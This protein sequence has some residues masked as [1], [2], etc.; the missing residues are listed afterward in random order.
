M[1]RAL[2]TVLFLACGLAVAVTAQTPPPNHIDI[3]GRG[4]ARTRTAPDPII[5]NGKRAMIL[6]ASETTLDGR[7]V[8]VNAAENRLVIEQEKSRKHF[9]ISLNPKTKLKADRGTELAGKEKIDITDFKPGQR[10]KVI[11]TLGPTVVELRLRRQKDGAATQT[12]APP[13]P[14]DDKKPRPDVPA[15]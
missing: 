4:A 11:Y 15:R 14:H 12:A 1:K 3:E 9:N 6:A 8:A 10:V 7:I 2:L 13:P 5:D